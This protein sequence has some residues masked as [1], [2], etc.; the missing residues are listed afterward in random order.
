MNDLS[1]EYKFLLNVN[2]TTSAGEYNLQEYLEKG[3]RII[4]IMQEANKNEIQTSFI[5]G[6]HIEKEK[7]E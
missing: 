4:G 2:D 3:Y 1:Q 6:R 7:G 5:L